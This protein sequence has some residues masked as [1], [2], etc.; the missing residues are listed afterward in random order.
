MIL[1][2]STLQNNLAIGGAGADG[3]SSFGESLGGGIM[4]VNGATLTV[5]GSTLRGNQAV[6][7]ATAPP[8][9]SVPLTGA[10]LGGGIENLRGSTLTLLD[11]TLA[12]NVAQ[13]GSSNAG[14]G[15]A[16]LGAASTTT[17]R[18]P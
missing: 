10:G 12:D 14:R 9:V 8:T 5:S 17:A 1:S 4:N 16:A 11:T 18:P 2:N 13:G 6:G 3:V 7:G 15:G